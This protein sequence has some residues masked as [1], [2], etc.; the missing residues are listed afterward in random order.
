MMR[1]TPSLRRKQKTERPESP[2]RALPYADP[3]GGAPAAQRAEAVGVKKRFLKNERRLPPL[4]QA[5]MQKRGK[6]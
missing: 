1:W 2:L 6:S 3:P 4:T 5:K